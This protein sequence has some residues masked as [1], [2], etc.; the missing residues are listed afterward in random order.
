MGLSIA[1]WLRNNARM[2]S[3]RARDV[4]TTG[5]FLDKCEHF[6]VAAVSG[7]LSASKITVAR[8][9]GKTKYAAMMHECEQE[10]VK[11]LAGL[12]IRSTERA[13]DHWTTRADAIIDEKSPPIERPCELTYNTTMDDVTRGTFS[14]NEAA[15]TEFDKAIQTAMTYPGKDKETR[16]HA[17]RQGDALF[18]IATFFNKNHAGSER[19]R[20]LPNVTLSADIGGDPT[21]PSPVFGQRSRCHRR[22]MASR[23]VSHST[24]RRTAHLMPSGGFR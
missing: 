3:Q 21:S 15:G 22:P 8:R 11:L 6:A 2:T 24:A 14:L 18:D 16:T 23:F 20:D 10:L 9:T 13:V 7:A 5:R 17:E 19:P 1:A 12:D 4:V